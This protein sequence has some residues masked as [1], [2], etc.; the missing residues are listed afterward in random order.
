[1]AEYQPPSDREPDAVQKLKTTLETA[2]L[3][4]LNGDYNPLHASPEA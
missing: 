3:Y 1:M 4:R 2:H